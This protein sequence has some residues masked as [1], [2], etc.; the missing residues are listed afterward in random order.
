M[1]DVFLRVAPI[2][3]RGFSNADAHLRE[4]LKHNLRESMQTRPNVD[5]ERSHRNLHLEGEETT[6]GVLKVSRTLTGTLR[7]K[8]K[9]SPRAFEFVVSLPANTDIDVQV[10]FHR[11]LCWLKA[12]FGLPVLAADVH[13][14]ECAPH[15]HVLFS[16]VQEGRLL[17][18]DDIIGGRD[19][20]KA[21]HRDFDR[22]VATKFGLKRRALLRGPAREELWRQ[23]LERVLSDP[24]CAR[25]SLE[26]AVRR[27]LAQF[28]REVGVAVPVPV[29]RLKTF[30]QIMTSPGKGPKV[31]RFGTTEWQSL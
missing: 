18:R 17:R 9:D 12:R 7:F 30:T 29:R 23:V 19:A 24:Q 2:S 31:E 14:D 6:A 3:G 27:D 8:R 4:A 13:L 16:P 21:L 5:Q 1:D 28:A 26:A 20:L 15:C 10:Y 25:V 11:S 22:E